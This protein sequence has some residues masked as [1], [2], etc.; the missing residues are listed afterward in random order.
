[1]WVS[2]VAWELSLPWRFTVM[3]TSPASE[4]MSTQ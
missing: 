3:L 2:N 1:M 4:Q